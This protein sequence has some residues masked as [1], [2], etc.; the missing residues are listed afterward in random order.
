M[1]VRANAAAAAA[2]ALLGG[3]NAAWN[4]HNPQERQ[5]ERADHRLAGDLDHQGELHLLFRDG[6]LKR[7]QV[8]V[9]E[10]KQYCK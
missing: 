3:K 10:Y 5:Q 6:F 9:G 2:V 4:Q 7:S 1:P 8:C